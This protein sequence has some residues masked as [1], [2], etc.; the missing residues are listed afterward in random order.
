MSFAPSEPGCHAYHCS[1]AYLF[2]LLINIEEHVLVPGGI[3]Y[4][5][6]AV[7]WSPLVSDDVTHGL[8]IDCMI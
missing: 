8:H 4:T 1:H 2:I 6:T 7:E 5:L 3:L